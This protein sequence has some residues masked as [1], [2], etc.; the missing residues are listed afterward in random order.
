MKS[1]LRALPAALIGVGL[2]ACSELS[3]VTDPDGPDALNIGTTSQSQSGSGLPFA[4]GE[5]LDTLEGRYSAVGRLVRFV[6]DYESGERSIVV[7]DEQ[8]IL[9]FVDDPDAAF[10]ESLTFNGETY[11]FGPEGEASLP[12]GQ[13][14][15]V[16]AVDSA[17]D[18]GI[19]NLFS[20][21]LDDGFDTDGFIVLGLQTNPS[22]LRTTG[23]SSYAGNLSG[24]GNLFD[25]NGNF[26]EDRVF[27]DGTATI[28]INFDDR[29]VTDTTVFLEVE[30][31]PAL[32]TGLT[33]TGD[34]S[35]IVGNGFADTLG[36]EGCPADATCSGGILLG[37]AF[38]GETGDQ[39]AGNIA[40]DYLIEVADPD[41]SD[42]F[43]GAG[44][45]IALEE[46]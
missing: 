33:F 18:V 6:A 45:F 13:F 19:L 41:D 31:P 30:N 5:T 9:N 21:S 24:F 14:L 7:T 40:V 39:L 16:Q 28:D 36:F 26:L 20:Y 3:F 12:N 37:G 15:N 46:P 29:A 1:V 10:V 11:D 23:T 25:G 43:I 27:F 8:L 17:A 2:S 42:R 35:E 4:G 22:G 34:G 44:Y 38:F 32:Y